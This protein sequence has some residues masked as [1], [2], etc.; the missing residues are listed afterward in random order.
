MNYWNPRTEL[1][2]RAFYEDA[3]TRD[4]GKC[5]LGKM[6]NTSHNS[7]ARLKSRLRAFGLT[8]V[9]DDLHR[10]QKDNPQKVEEVSEGTTSNKQRPKLAESITY[11]ESGNVANV[12]LPETRICTLDQLLEHCGFDKDVW[13][14][15]TWEANKWEVGAKDKNKNVQIHPL[16]QVKA[17][18]KKR[19]SVELAKQVID[20]LILKAKG[21]MP[22]VA[23]YLHVL[24]GERVMVTI[25]TPDLH[26]NKLAWEEETGENYDTRIAETR[27]KVSVEDLLQ[28]SVASHRNRISLITHPIGNDLF[29][30]DGKTGTTTG[31]TP[32]N[33]DSRHQKVFRKVL[34]MKIAAIERMTEVAPVHVVIVP[35]NHDEET[36]F[37]LGMALEMYF[38]NNANV[39]V[40]NLACLRKFV[41]FGENMLMYCHGDKAIDK[42]PMIMATSQKEMW[43]RTSFR[44]AHCGHFHKNKVYGRIDVDEHHGV[45]VRVLPSLCGTDAW[46]AGMGYVGNLKSAQ[47]YIYGE[48]QGLVGFYTHTVR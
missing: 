25:N 5:R 1:G 4:I 29:N 42:L 30:V 48:E 36:S 17:R 7:A 46:H 12:L 35:G 21:Q 33:T 27:Y 44:E 19:E 2:I 16:Y 8:A 15:V 28:K 41:E 22:V 11:S 20:D 13:E 45:V 43:A 24:S 34:L 40:D 23:P 3:I 6:Y 18:F 38:A 14:V 32:Q 39:T 10:W 31:G 26:M 47:A 37:Y 9:I